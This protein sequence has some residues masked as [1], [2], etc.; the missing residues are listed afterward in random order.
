MDGIHMEPGKGGGG[1]GAERQ[2]HTDERWRQTKEGPL[3][4][5]RWSQ[6]SGIE[7]GVDDS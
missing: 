6:M 7:G 2:R 5:S 1:G 4:K 3:N